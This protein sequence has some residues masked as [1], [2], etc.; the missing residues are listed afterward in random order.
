MKIISH[1]GNLNGCL[2]DK[3]NHPS[4]IQSAVDAGYDTEIDVWWYKDQFYL[5]HDEP[6]Y[7]VTVSW[8]MDLA[9]VLWC[10]AKNDDAFVRLLQHGL[11]C[12]WH[13][14]DRF[15][16]TSKGIPWCY[17]ENFI[18]GG[19]TV[20]KEPLSASKLTVPVDILGVCTD[21]PEY[22]RTK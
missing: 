9:H 20:I 1:R 4:Y 19:I 15:T 11:H 16:L 22:W 5:G 2:P 8:L 18:R 12:F 6:Q 7:S 21:S 3:E 17:P 14:N 13:E 10:H